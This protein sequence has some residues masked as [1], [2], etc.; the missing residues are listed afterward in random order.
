MIMYYRHKCYN[1]N[2]QKRSDHQ[3]LLE[4]SFDCTT[5]ILEAKNNYIL[6]M[7]TKL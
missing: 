4:K 2:G 5:E 7:T 1:K 6:K 3:K